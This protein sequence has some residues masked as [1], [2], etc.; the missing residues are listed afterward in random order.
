MM[1]NMSIFSTIVP[2]L[3]VLSAGCNGVNY[4]YTDLEGNVSVDG[5]VL[6]E[7]SLAFYPQ[8]AGKGKGVFVP[9]GANGLYKAEK[10]PIGKTQVTITSMKKSG[11]KEISF[12]QE[13]D[14]MVSVIPERYK[15]GGIVAEILPG[16]TELNFELTSKPPAK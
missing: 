2:L 7:G 5:T 15:G 11:K 12:G 9:I 16:Q 1:K 6:T 14:E 13:M 4:D 10:V 8:D 3:L